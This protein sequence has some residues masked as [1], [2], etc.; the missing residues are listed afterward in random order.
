[1]I[2]VTIDGQT[3]K[4]AEGTT[5]L[6]AARANGILIP[7]LC[8][9]KDLNEV[10]AC[11]I[12]VVEVKGA[13][14]LVSACNTVAT[15][16][17]EVVTTSPRVFA[18]RKRNLQLILSRHNADCLVCERN[19]RCA[20]QT[21]ARQ[22]GLLD[23]VAPVDPRKLAKDRP[24]K[25][26]P[27]YRT[28]SRCISCLRCVNVCEKV[29][30]M[31]VWDLIGLGKA[32]HVGVSGGQSL[33]DASCTFCGQ[34]VTHCPVSALNERDDTR[35]FREAVSDPKKTVVVQV[36]PAVRAAWG[37]GLGIPSAK[38]TARRLV[39]ALK[40]LGANKVFDTNFAAD[41]TILEEGHE[42]I[43]RLKTKKD[44]P[45]FTS[46]CPGWVRFLKLEYPEMLAHLSTAKSPQQMMGAVIKSYFAEK[47]KLDP[48]NIVSV[49]VM[50]CTA[51]KREAEEGGDVDI[52]LTTREVE[53]LLKLAGVDAATLPEKDFD[54]PLGTGS[55]AGVIFGATGGVM[56]AALRTAYFVLEGKNPDPDAFKAVRGIQGRKEITATLG[57]M[58]VKACVVSGLKNARTLVEEVKNGKA[59][60]DF[61]EVMA[62]PGGCVGGGGQPFFDGCELAE[63][64]GEALYALD[65]ANAIRFSHENPEVAALYRE[66]LGEPFGSKAHELL[67]V[68]HCA[69]R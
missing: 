29:Q 19:G 49:S 28:D 53:R 17:M 24:D 1:M 21:L 12:C 63:E 2:T 8:Y 33:K 67:H 45:L 22:M 36:A 65:K 41:L 69:C 68:G 20:L 7:T 52:V 3:L 5:I 51:K 25:T 27:F 32:A 55:G 59:Q 58:P 50:P 26:L 16:G 56:E 44:L 61:I 18:A 48:A 43:E 6:E 34:C 57:G 60:Y 35:R 23:N 31:G 38:A 64:R 14:R 66:F 54:S 30:G 37:D 9:L 39:A 42:L 4:V 40:R 46:C 13:E 47:E 15:D 10:G 62:C 11:R